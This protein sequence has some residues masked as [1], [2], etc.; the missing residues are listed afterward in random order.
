MAAIREATAS[1][2]S[3]S[4]VIGHSIVGGG[5]SFT[6][7]KPA[8]VGI[9]PRCDVMPEE[10]DADLGRSNARSRS[11]ALPRGG[12]IGLRA[13]MAV[14]HRAFAPGQVQGGVGETQVRQRLREIAAKPSA[15]W[16]VL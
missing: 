4:F 3:D 7:G 9:F 16:V 6:W 8:A 12:G 10:A 11:R 13:G 2:A 5:L 14:A 15:A 1:V